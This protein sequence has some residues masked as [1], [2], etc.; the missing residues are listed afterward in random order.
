MRVLLAVVTGLVFLWECADVRDLTGVRDGMVRGRWAH[1]LPLEDSHLPSAKDKDASQT[2]IFIKTEVSTQ[3]II[4][5]RHIV[6]LFTYLHCI[7]LNLFFI[8]P[9]L[10]HGRCLLLRFC[11]YIWEEAHHHLPENSMGREPHDRRVSEHLF[12]TDWNLKVL[13]LLKGDVRLSVLRDTTYSGPPRRTPCL[14]SP[15]RASL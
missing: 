14:V 1:I 8:K 3:N 12:V 9:S 11:F 15:H 10:G 5:P 2:S 7:E 4:H 13:E 6:L